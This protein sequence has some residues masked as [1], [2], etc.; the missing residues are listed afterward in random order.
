MTRKIAP[1]TIEHTHPKAAQ[2][3][4]STP[5]SRTSSPV[6]RS[7]FM[8]VAAEYFR[9][10]EA[11]LMKELNEEGTEAAETPDRPCE[12]TAPDG[13]QFDEVSIREALILCEMLQ[14]YLDQLSPQELKQLARIYSFY[15]NPKEMLEKI[16]IL[17]TGDI[18]VKE[19]IV[20]IY[21]AKAIGSYKVTKVILTTV[22]LFENLQAEESKRIQHELKENVEESLKK[23]KNMLPRALQEMRPWTRTNLC[24]NIVKTLQ[25]DKPLFSK[26][27]R[28]S[29]IVE[30]FREFIYWLYGNPFILRYIEWKQKYLVYWLHT[31]L[32]R[33]DI[34]NMA[35]GASALQYSPIKQKIYQRMSQYLSSLEPE[36]RHVDQELLLKKSHYALLVQKEAFLP[37]ASPSLQASM[38]RTREAEQK[39]LDNLTYNQLT[40]LAAAIHR[41]VAQAHQ[42]QKLKGEVPANANE[43]SLDL[44]SERKSEQKYLEATVKVQV[45][46]AKSK[47]KSGAGF[48]IALKKFTEKLG[49][50]QAKETSPKEV[51]VEMVPRTSGNVDKAL[52][53]VIPS[54]YGFGKEYRSSIYEVQMPNLQKIFFEH[55]GLKLFLH[56]DFLKVFKAVMDFYK[57]LGYLKIV[58]HKVT[59]KNN[60]GKPLEKLDEEGIYL[61]TAMDEF[62]V[63]GRAC[64]YQSTIP[65]PYF[66]LYRLNPVKV[67]TGSSRNI[68]Y[69]RVVDGKTFHLESFEQ[70]TQVRPILF[71][72]LIRVIDSLPD[73][74]RNAHMNFLKRLHSFLD[75]HPSSKDASTAND[76]SSPEALSTPEEIT[77]TDNAEEVKGSKDLK[78]D[79]NSPKE[80]NVIV[81]DD[82][83]EEENVI[84]EDDY[85]EEEDL[86]SEDD[87]SEGEDLISEDDYSEGEDLISEDDY[88]EEEDLISDDYSTT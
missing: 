62:L 5:T 74:I 44:E 88:S 85:S 56:Q 9:E 26:T 18:T 68:D 63:L 50:F 42:Q 4:P 17:F 86:I 75:T 84:I 6:N 48:L 12:I 16:K 80:A 31:E 71:K 55:G 66:Q 35:D 27:H 24:S 70:P 59:L 13:F 15:S 46:Q 76:D 33:L 8:N 67:Y 57:D 32:Y 81:K 53:P 36:E 82:D 11:Q 52:E 37:E 64:F 79:D 43:R 54:W 40:S 30:R 21:S 72:C 73:P 20:R 60:E 7:K 47:G 69:S 49:L 29:L 51:K 78:I 77:R 19:K 2:E 65:T 61:R 14:D 58:T 1:K 3:S 22:E 38:I 83:S 28:Y 39:L 10:L 41:E 34:K 25:Y 87:Y 45:E 23:I